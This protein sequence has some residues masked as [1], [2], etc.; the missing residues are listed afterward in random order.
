LPLLQSRS[1]LAYLLVVVAAAGL[2]AATGKPS[3]AEVTGGGQLIISEFRLQG[4]NGIQDEFIEIYNN[5]GTS[6]FVAS[7]SGTGYGVA[8]SDGTLRF[9]IPNGITIPNGGHYLGVNSTGG[10]YSL[11]AYPAGN[12]NTATGDATYST[13]IPLNTGIALFNTN[14]PANFS[15]STLLD[16][17]GSTNEANT[18]YR[19]GA[20]YAPLSSGSSEHTIFR[21][22]CGNGGSVTSTT[23]CTTGG[24]PK[25]TDNNATDF[26]VADTL[27]SNLGASIRQGAPGPE[28]MSSP[29]HRSGNFLTRSLLDPCV[30]AASPP[31]LIRDFTSD[32]VNNSN[33]GA[34]DIRRTF[35]NTTGQPIS[36]LRFRI[37][38]LST[39]PAPSGVADL[40]AR[41]GGDLTV[42]VD[43]P[44]CGSATSNVTV[45]GT[46]LEQ[47]PNQP[48]GGAFNSSL[49]VND[50]TLATPLANGA[51]ID[52][53]F[54]F[55]IQQE[56]TYK[57]G[58]VPETLPTF[59]AQVLY[60]NGSTITGESFE[61]SRP[62]ANDDGAT[63]TR[64]SGAN[65]IDVLA[66]DTD[67]GG[68]SFTVTNVT[69]PAHG[70]AAIT[71]SGTGVGYTPDTNYVGS[72]VFTYTIAT[73]DGRTDTAMVNIT[74][75][76]PANTPTGTSTSTATRTATGVATS[77]ATNIAQA[78]TTNTP[79][80]TA[81][82][83]PQQTA[84][85]TSCPIEFQDVPSDNTFYS[86]VRCL[87]CK[88]ILG[89]YQCGGADEPCGPSGDPYFR[90]SV[91]ISRGQIAKIVSE[92]AGL[93][94]PPG[95]RIF[96]DV[97]EDSAFFAY[98][99]RLTNEG[100]MGGYP[101]G[102][103]DEE[104]CE[105]AENR[106]YFRPSAKATRGQ[107]S[108]IVANAAGNNT[109]V[110]QQTYEDVPGDSPFY[111]YIER[112]SALNVMSGYP[113]GGP[114]EACGAGNRPFFRP[115]ANVTRGQAAKIVANTFF[116]G[117]QTP[118]RR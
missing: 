97:P 42:T 60:I 98:I 94:D 82:G 8:A 2:L 16:A 87:A 54:V 115:N 102:L 48:N 116:P 110:S 38:D 7:T 85:A 112:L 96:E 20:G 99:Q 23:A 111:L 108:K 15:S 32:P 9:T 14:V 11:S 100:H 1:Y 95:P 17:V 109:P 86:V 103:R 12:G 62:V 79:Q 18:L 66:N 51:S 35:T 74:V 3:Q 114:G 76:E 47:P 73:S 13:E 104:P 55:G 46:T 4:P 39:Y 24:S 92:S 22:M 58:I 80:P 72:D 68:S 49:S 43:R 29:I 101:C 71:G 64:N 34:L 33:F 21:D 117:C 83:G 91:Q 40:R 59:G 77:T 26:V 56:G 50:I 78:T 19:E 45:Q 113:C 10:F 57:I 67:P 93:N 65:S 75:V 118:A 28:N 36:R 6:H 52:V 27:G 105:T 70:T 107:L 41:T 44:P 61:G 63:V 53:R 88:N 25:D 31:N 90:P 89:G 81:T 30:S 84:T 37:V 106:P 69:D 5:S